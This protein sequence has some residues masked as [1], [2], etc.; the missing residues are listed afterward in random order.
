MDSPSLSIYWHQS[1][2]GHN[3]VYLLYKTEEAVRDLRFA[4]RQLGDDNF[5]KTTCHIQSNVT[6][7]PPGFLNTIEAFAPATT[8]G[9]GSTSEVQKQP[10]GASKSENATG[11]YL[12]GKRTRD[13]APRL[14]HQPKKRNRD[15]SSAIPIA[16]P[17]LPLT[18]L[19]TDYLPKAGPPTDSLRPSKRPSSQDVPTQSTALELAQQA[20]E[21]ASSKP[22]R[23]RR[24]HDDED[25]QSELECLKKER[26]EAILE[27]DAALESC[28]ALKQEL[29]SLK[30]S[31]KEKRKKSDK[32]IHLVTASLQSLQE[33]LKGE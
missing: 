30:R 13:D 10:T 21:I 15:S 22:K 6:N 4:L 27:R 18:L 33:S 14:G 20:A 25:H 3:N 32:V 9:I 26:D 28:Q 29:R 7:C 19:E 16:S 2:Q 11:G 24:A 12:L 1:I 31:F 8:S 5:W 23:T 17:T